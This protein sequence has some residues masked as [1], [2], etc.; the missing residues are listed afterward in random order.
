MQQEDIESDVAAS[1]RDLRLM[2]TWRAT[3]QVALRDIK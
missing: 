2:E 1:W 3:F